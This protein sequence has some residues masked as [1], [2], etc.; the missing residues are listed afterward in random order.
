MQSKTKMSK[1]KNTKLLLAGLLLIA[2]VGGGF[3]Y[4]NHH[5]K[6]D[7]TSGTANNTGSPQDNSS[8]KQSAAE[9]KKKLIEGNS[10]TK[11]SAGNMSIGL[12]AQQ[13]NNNTVTVFT[14]LYGYSDGTCNLS[15]SNG[16]KSYST[17][18]AVI[19]Q[20]D[21][22]SCEGFT[23]PINKL[24]TGTWSIKLSVE[25]KGKTYHKTISLGVY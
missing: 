7:S 20:A 23:V 6:A 14:K 22:S 17:S 11:A 16:S 19:Y 1:I 5:G 10:D 13:E 25:T 21:F 18:A 4:F 24:G 2:V 15:V 8:E 3:Y 9:T 12:S